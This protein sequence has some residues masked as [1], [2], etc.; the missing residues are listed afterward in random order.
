MT[1]STEKI[2]HSDSEKVA[3]DSPQHKRWI[4]AAI[5]V[6][7]C[8]VVILFF[9]RSKPTA[10]IKPTP[11]VG[12]K[13]YTDPLH[14]FR[15]TVPGDWVTQQEQ[16]TGIT[17]QHTAHPVTQQVEISQLYIPPEEGITIQVY[18]VVPTCPLESKLTTTM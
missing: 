13:V 12:E 17:G 2:I 6:L 14:D 8:M 7:L 18:T 11:S 5:I 3:E 15:I 16:G 4:L 9:Y 10:S 1:D